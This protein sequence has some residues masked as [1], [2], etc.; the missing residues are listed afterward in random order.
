MRVAGSSIIDGAAAGEAD[1]IAD[2]ARGGDPVAELA[3]LMV[4][5][6]MAR[7]AASTAFASKSFA[8]AATLWQGVTSCSPFGR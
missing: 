4:C 6:W 2:A 5:V 3:V 1:E 8:A 7:I